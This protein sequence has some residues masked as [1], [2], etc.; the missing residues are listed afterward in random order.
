M[1][2]LPP[3]LVATLDQRA[4]TAGV[5]RSQMIRDAIAAFLQ[6]GTDREAALAA[7]YKDA[8]ARLPLDTPDEWGDLESWHAGLEQA[9]AAGAADPGW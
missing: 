4:A 5:S 7:H 6:A 9:R 8:Y 1:V 2:Q 3:D